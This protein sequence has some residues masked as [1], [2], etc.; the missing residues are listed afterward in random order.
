[1]NSSWSNS[2][3]EAADTNERPRNLER[4]TTASVA[5]CRRLHW[6]ERQMRGSSSSLS[7]AEN[8]CGAL[9]A[10]GTGQKKD[11][12]ATCFD[13]DRSMQDRIE[14]VLHGMRSSSWSLCR[15][16]T[17]FWEAGEGEEHTCRNS[18]RPPQRQNEQQRL[19]TFRCPCSLRHALAA[20]TASPA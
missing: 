2:C 11:Y 17:V 1:M 4:P 6:S 20:V 3:P 9:I 18:T 10:S 16:G 7:V 5:G 8:F 15:R 14:F 12:S 13:D 19:T